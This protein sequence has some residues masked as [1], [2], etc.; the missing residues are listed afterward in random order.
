M[1]MKRSKARTAAVPSPGTAPGS[2]A[3]SHTGMPIVS[4]CAEHARERRLPD[5]A[6]GRVGHAREGDD[7]LRVGEHGQV[8]DRVLD[9]RAL[10]E[11]RA[12][13]DL[14]ADLA[15]HERV[16]EHPRLRVGPVEDRD[17]RA[18]D[19]LVDQ[20]LDLPH[21]EPRL[22]VLVLELAHLDRIALAE[23]GPQRLPHPPAVVRDDRV[24]D[25]EDRL[26]RAVVLLEPHDL[27]VRVVV[28]EIEDVRDVRA[29]E[30]VDRVVGDEPGGDEVVRALDVEVVDGPVELDPLDRLDDVVAAV[31]GEHRHARADDAAVMNGSAFFMPATGA[32]PRGSAPS[33]RARGRDRRR[34]AASKS[35]NTSRAPARPA[36]RPR[37]ALERADLVAAAH[38]D[39][40]IGVGRDDRRTA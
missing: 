19:A 14:V 16:L 7:V 9:L 13:D 6:L 31:L 23:V 17:L 39:R 24:G 21:H 5:P 1:A 4:A 37:S 22:G 40:C 20:P 35:L 15:A 33:R 8:G 3:A 32:Q 18:R 10:V 27:G 30:A 26:R 11:L 38:R 34:A 36:S 2:A 28:L 29:A 12:A 25:A